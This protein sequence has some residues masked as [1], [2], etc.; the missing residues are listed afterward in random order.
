M[1]SINPENYNIDSFNSQ[2]LGPITVQ[3]FREYVLNHNLPGLDTVLAQNGID[4]YGLNIY[5]PLLFNPTE[6]V[7]DLPN[8]SEVSFLPSPINDNTSPRPDNKKRNLFTNSKPFIG[9]PT[10]EETFEV[11]TKALED[12]GSIDSWVEEAGFSTD[13]FSVRNFNNLTNNE[14]GPE[15][16][17][18]YNDPDQPLESTGYKQY[19]SDAGGDVIG[20]IIAR[21]LG[22]SPENFINFPSPLQDTAKER[23]IEELTNRV[24][25]NFVDDTVGRLNLDPLGLLAGQSIFLPDY[26]ITKRKGLLGKAAQFTASL[27]GFNWPRSPLK[28]GKNPDLGSNAFQA[29]LLDYTGKAQRKILYKNVYSSKYT[30]ELLTKGYDLENA[31]A[32]TLNAGGAESLGEGKKK[33]NNYLKLNKKLNKDESTRERRLGNWL[34][35][36][37]TKG[38]QT[39][40][41]ETDRLT[42]PSDPFVTMGIDGQYPSIDNLDPN[43]T[44]VELDFITPPSYQYGGENYYPNKTTLKPSQEDSDDAL[45]SFT[46]TTPGTKNL[47]YWQNRDRSVGKRGLLDFTQKMI[48][49]ADSNGYRGGAKFIGRLDSD[50]NLKSIPTDIGDG[51]TRNIPRMTEVSKGN[52]LRGG[53]GDHYCRSWNTRNPYQN[54]YDLIRRSRL[55]RAGGGSDTGPFPGP[56]QS[57]LED[58][59]HVKIAPYGT[60]D[61]EIGS[62]VT[63][64]RGIFNSGNDVKRYMFSI[65]N[66]A[67]ADAPE[68]IGLEPCE[69]GP[70]G[71][72]IMWFP[73]YDINFTDN[74]TANWDSTVFLGRAEPVYTYNHTERKGTL[75]WSI[76]TDHPSVLNKLKDPLEGKILEFFAGCGVDV[77]KFYEEIKEE[78]IKTEEWLDEE[79][80]KKPIDKPKPIIPPPVIKK[81]PPVKKLSF[82]F[83]NATNDGRAKG[84]PGVGRTIEKEIAVNY[85]TGKFSSDGVGQNQISKTKTGDY[86]MLNEKQW[87]TTDGDESKGVDALI[88]FLAT[89]DGQEWS[90]KLEGFCSAASTDKYNQM[91]SI[92]RVQRVYEYM[93]KG[94]KEIGETGGSGYT[95]I[96]ENFKKVHFGYKCTDGKDDKR[97]SYRKQKDTELGMDSRKCAECFSVGKQYGYYPYVGSIKDVGTPK[98]ENITE[99][100]LSKLGRWITVAKSE[101]YAA[102]VDEDGL[103]LESE[104]EDGTSISVGTQSNKAKEDRRVT[105]T[106]FRNHEYVAQNT[107]VEN[108][109]SL[110][111]ELELTSLPLQPLP[112]RIG[113]EPAGPPKIYQ[114]PGL[115]GFDPINITMDANGNILNQG[116]PVSEDT[117]EPKKTRKERRLEKKKKANDEYEKEVVTSGGTKTIKEKYGETIELPTTEALL[118]QKAEEDLAKQGEQPNGGTD[119]NVNDDEIKENPIITE[120]VVKRVVQKLFR[121]C[122]YFEKIKVSDPFLYETIEE[123]VKFFHP[124]FHSI[125]PEGLNSRLTFLQQC[126]RQGPSLRDSNNITQNMAFGKPPV[127]ILR[128]GDFYYTKIIP[129]SLNVNY[130]PLQWDMNPEGVGVQPM[131]AKVD[132]NFSMVG[133][134][135]LDGP[136]DRLQNAVSFNFFAN[137]SVYNPRRYYDG[138]IANRSAFKTM[139]EKLE[140]DANQIE[141]NNENIGFGAFKSQNQASKE[142]YGKDTG[143]QQS[144]VK[145][146]DKDDGNSNENEEV[147]AAFY[148]NDL[149]ISPKGASI[150]EEQKIKT[151][152]LIDPNQPNREV[153]EALLTGTADEVEVGGVDPTTSIFYNG[154]FMGTESDQEE[155]SNMYP[156]ATT[157]LI[158]LRSDLFYRVQYKEVVE[159]PFGSIGEEVLTGN[160]NPQVNANESSVQAKYPDGTGGILLD[161][162]TFG[163]TNDGRKQGWYISSRVELK[164]TYPNGEVETLQDKAYI[165]PT[166]TSK[167][168]LGKPYTDN[169]VITSDPTMVLTFEVQRYF[170]DWFELDGFENGNYKLDITWIY[171][172]E[173]TEETLQ[174]DTT[175]KIGDLVVKEYTESLV[176]NLYD[177]EYVSTTP[178]GPSPSPTP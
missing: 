70:N 26:T 122:E 105:V 86:L 148:F 137:T 18:T 23:R 155:I 170:L 43:S 172:R 40:Q 44:F 76:I 103:P 46:H 59:G 134:S 14:Y 177:E 77:T 123:K 152:V 68:K 100:E 126:L 20:P 106:L 159:L 19:P 90:I 102:Q 31:G 146:D 98:S 60:D 140:E 167:E 84:R 53:D 35:D 96:P 145:K 94:V 54:H 61:F 83:R 6:T 42:T 139:L 8:L 111:S 121:E 79:V 73:P 45:N 65:E 74:T 39:L 141:L 7:N 33:P 124:A 157:P 82:Y 36:L 110:S 4:N 115:S 3:G 21:S 17:E 97:T 116:V 81:E 135:S 128:I 168:S 173:V 5:A 125:T 10:E 161:T 37:T 78:I 109:P 101:D 119:E 131:I 175:K 24:K 153:D 158:E 56:Y 38:D 75:S 41:P 55:Y 144:N 154:G 80:I 50:S 127:L 93:A 71:G 133:G 29:D 132:L 15:F 142:F 108:D 164:M 118:K 27:G 112:E 92:D 22:F 64:A 143:G 91:L 165:I 34:R 1:P 150:P 51:E 147:K 88:D 2:N 160:I 89:E 130:E 66:L 136:I 176:Y 13:V 32:D 104:Q 174:F 58:N 95:Y 156:G 120:K 57:T 149:G 11:T 107:K 129:D 16:V 69:I 99:E 30:P 72:R 117:V 169:T 163:I 166:T 49:N 63:N 87:F 151:N 113:P 9:S 28:G 138:N 12:P 178:I 52:L 85:D 114:I 162:I 47:F 67:W 171:S 48:N 25:L 62:N